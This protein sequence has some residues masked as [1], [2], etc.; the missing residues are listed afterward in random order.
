[1]SRRLLVLAG[2][3]AGLTWAAPAVAASPA[4]VTATGTQLIRVLPKNR[5]LNSSIEAAVTAAQHAGIQGALVA[6]HQ[7][8]VDYA[9]GAG[10]TLGP[11]ISIT[12]VQTNPQYFGPYGGGFYGPFGP[13]QYCGIERRPVFKSV[14]NRRKLVRFKKVHAC[15]V[16]RFET[17]A[18]TVTYSAQ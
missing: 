14:K 2:I 16:P 1:M 3:V 9:K 13:D 6:A 10:L 12:D 7:N 5:K 11:V 17:T 8:A 4:T 18:L 15:V